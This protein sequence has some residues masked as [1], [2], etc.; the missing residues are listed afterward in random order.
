MAYLQTGLNARNIITKLAAHKYGSTD[1]V[2][3]MLDFASGYGRVTRFLVNDFNPEKIWVSDIKENGVQFQKEVFGVNGVNSSYVPEEFQPGRKFQVIFVGS[4]FSHLPDDLFNRWLS[5]LHS[6]LN[7][8]GLLIFSVLD[9]ERH[10][11]PDAEYFEYKMVSED[12]AFSDV[13]DSIKE[14]SNYGMAYV[15]K[16]YMDDSLTKIE[17][18]KDQFYVYKNSFGTIQDVYAVSKDSNTFN[19]SLDLSSYP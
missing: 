18:Q 9:L 6:L 19:D 2:E 12:Q 16:K 5:Q 11:S 10:G 14:I 15:S 4:L 3:S 13:N 7:E 8:N 1:N 17:V